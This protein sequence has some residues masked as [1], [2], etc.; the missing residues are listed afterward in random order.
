MY[1]VSCRRCCA[2]VEFPNIESSR[3]RWNKRAD[4]MISVKDRL[5]ENG[6]PVIV[7]GGLAMRKTGGEWFTGMEEPLYMR[8]IEW[9]VTH[10]MPLPAP[11][12]VDD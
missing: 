3:N 5:P 12:K 7:S 4:G 1:T 2:T 11:P 10:W 6:V 8:K 9:E